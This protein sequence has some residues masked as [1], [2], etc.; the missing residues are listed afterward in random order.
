MPSQWKVPGVRPK[1][2]SPELLLVTGTRTFDDYD[3]LEWRCELITGRWDDVVVVHGHSFH[4][5]WGP[6]GR[7]YTGADWHAEKW[8]EKNWYDRQHFIADWDRYGKAAGPRR[9][10][11]M[12]RHVLDHGGFMVAFWDG[13]SPGTADT[14]RRFTEESDRYFIQR[15]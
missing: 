13:K 12:V 2:V 6:R 4:G 11:E 1:G 14:I 15:Y 8:A 5:A 3:I 7:R 9:N 10:A